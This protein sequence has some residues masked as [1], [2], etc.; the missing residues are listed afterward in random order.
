MLVDA[1]EG[2]ARHPLMKR[3][4]W[5]LVAVYNRLG[6]GGQSILKVKDFQFYLHEWVKRLVDVPGV[7]AWQDS[8]S[9]ME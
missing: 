1:Y 5:G 3:S 2:R 7:E 8:Y 6:S 9:R 4:A